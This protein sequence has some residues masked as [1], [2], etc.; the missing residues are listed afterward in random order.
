MQDCCITS[1]VLPVL[2][3]ICMAGLFMDSAPIPSSA[4]NRSQ[5]SLYCEDPFVRNV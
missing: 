1:I 3:R 5:S 4:G 2:A